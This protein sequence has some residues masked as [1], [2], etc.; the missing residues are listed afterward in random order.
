MATKNNSINQQPP[1]MSSITLP[2]GGASSGMGILTAGSTTS[3]QSDA[4]NSYLQGIIRNASPAATET[5][6]VSVSF[7]IIVTASLALQTNPNLKFYIGTDQAAGSSGTFDSSF[8]L[9]AS[10]TALQGNCFMQ[11]PVLVSDI[12]HASNTALIIKVINNTGISVDVEGISRF[13]PVT[14]LYSGLRTS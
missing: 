4:V 1:V 14:Y 7:S 11:V 3:W 13:M 2:A 12:K 8:L 9:N 10:A 6:L 5:L